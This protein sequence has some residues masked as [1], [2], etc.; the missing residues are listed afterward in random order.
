MVLQTWRSHGHRDQRLRLRR[1]VHGIVDVGR[2]GYRFEFSRCIA[3]IAAPWAAYA[4]IPYT[5]M[6]ITRGIECIE[7]FLVLERESERR[8]NT[9]ST[10]SRARVVRV[11]ERT[12]AALYLFYLHVLLVEFIVLSL[13]SRTHKHTP[14]TRENRRTRPPLSGP[15]PAPRLAAVAPRVA[16]T[17]TVLLAPS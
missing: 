5:C 16:S 12:L 8:M 2:H 15:P 13:S 9:S 14:T 10:S 1:V 17:T 4:W 3:M 6:D 11:Y 7:Q